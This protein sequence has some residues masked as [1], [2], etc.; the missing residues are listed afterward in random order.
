MA[1]KSKHLIYLKDIDGKK[2][3]CKV[4]DKTSSI[5]KGYKLTSRKTKLYI[6]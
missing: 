3:N 2:M 5:Y 6:I 4:R 1:R